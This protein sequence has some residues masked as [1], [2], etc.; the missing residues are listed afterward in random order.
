[1]PA[2]RRKRR[3]ALSPKETA[4]ESADGNKAAKA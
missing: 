2:N 3:F 1:L 4:V